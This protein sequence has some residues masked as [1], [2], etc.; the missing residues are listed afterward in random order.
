M[1]IFLT[2]VVQACKT[3]GVDDSGHD[4]LVQTKRYHNEIGAGDNIKC[5]ARKWCTFHVIAILQCTFDIVGKS[6]PCFQL[7]QRAVN[8]M[9]AR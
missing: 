9:Q 6:F 8:D 7:G 1:H 2:S 4:Q 5:H 3:C